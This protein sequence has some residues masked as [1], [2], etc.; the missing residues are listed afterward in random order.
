MSMPHDDP[1]RPPHPRDERLVVE[2]LVPTPRLLVGWMG[3]AE[4]E[5]GEASLRVAMEILENPKFSR[6]TEAFVKP[7]VATSAHAFLEVGPR[8]SAVVVE[9]EPAT[10]HDPADVLTLLDYELET[11]T[12][13]GP[14]ATDV[15]FTKY[16]VHAHV[17]KDLAAAT[18]NATGLVHSS[19]VPKLLHALRPGG[20]DRL[21]RPSTR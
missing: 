9:I 5:V 3:P 18:A 16:Y 21:L 7:G 4:G 17:E 20:M 11:L 10:T 1:D 6:L 8:A 15:G 19:T 2:E 13:E 12:G 14:S